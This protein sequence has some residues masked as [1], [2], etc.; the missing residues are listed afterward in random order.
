MAAKSWEARRWPAD[1]LVRLFW[2]TSPGQWNTTRTNGLTWMTGYTS[3]VAVS[4]AVSCAVF[5]EVACQAKTHHTLDTHAACLRPLILWVLSYL[6]QGLS[7][8]CWLFS[9]SQPRDSSS[10]RQ[11]CPEDYDDDYIRLHYSIKSL[12]TQCS[13]HLISELTVRRLG[14]WYRESIT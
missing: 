9:Y 8:G 4:P 14:P 5:R 3:C 13:Y 1:R 11:L 2:N 10:N 7:P 6:I 12:Y